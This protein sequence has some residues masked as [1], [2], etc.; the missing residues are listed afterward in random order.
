MPSFKE[1]FLVRTGEHS[2]VLAA[3]ILR[4]AGQWAERLNEDPMFNVRLD[5]SEREHH[6]ARAW[7]KL[8]KD[9]LPTK[10]EVWVLVHGTLSC[11]Y[12]AFEGLPTSFFSDRQ[13]FRFEHDTCAEIE[14]NVETLLKILKDA[15]PEVGICLVAHSRGGIVARQAGARL[16]DRG[17]KVRVLTF[18]T[19]HKG[20]PLVM[21]VKGLLPRLKGAGRWLFTLPQGGRLF[22]F[23]APAAGQ[24]VMSLLARLG[25][26]NQFGL[27]NANAV[28]AANAY[29]LVR[30]GDLPAGIYEMR[31]NSSYLKGLEEP[32]TGCAS[33]GGKFDVESDPDGFG[34][35]FE[36]GLSREMFAHREN[37]L[38]VPT[39]SAL[40]FGDPTTVPGCAHTAYFARADIQNALR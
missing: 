7:P 26:A 11:C 2:G 21:Q 29:A 15:P 25:I 3:T 23:F 33:W 30:A 32:W 35:A 18:G 5:H 24:E 1:H 12:G 22:R 39:D 19:P 36:Q 34:I 9:C 6:S 40:A 38:I 17:V 13:V 4:A 16:N 14:D 8:V 10:G 31:E 20:T 37:D 27:S 28:L